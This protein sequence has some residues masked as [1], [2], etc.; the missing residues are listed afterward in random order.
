[1]SVTP[2]DAPLS[3]LYD[4]IVYCSTEG[5]G[6]FSVFVHGILVTPGTLDVRVRKLTEP[7]SL[8]A[9]LRR[10]RKS[11]TS[12]EGKERGVSDTRLIGKDRLSHFPGF[13]PLPT[14]AGIG[15]RKL[16]S[17]RNNLSIAWA[18]AAL[19]AERAALL[20]AR[21]SAFAL[22]VPCN[23]VSMN[24]VARSNRKIRG[25]VT[26]STSINPVCASAPF[27]LSRS[28]NWKKSGPCGRGTSS[29]PCALIAP[30]STPN[31]LFADG[32]SQT[33]IATRPPG[34]STRRISTNARSG[35]GK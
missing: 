34:R 29:R 9:P 25:T 20:C 2:R 28:P 7:A 23:T 12:T 13:T 18:V 14:M 27:I 26:A 1:M 16:S 4:R 35:S 19:I 31:P 10:R 3:K 8:H 33:L 17:A 6:L 11:M 24:E 32:R 21:S 15:T 22:T 30:I 5:K